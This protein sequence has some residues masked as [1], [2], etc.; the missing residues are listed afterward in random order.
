MTIELGL[1]AGGME[2]EWNTR[3]APLA[4]LSVHYQAQKRFQPLETLDIG[5]KTVRYSPVNK[6][7]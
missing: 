7:K 6:L 2:G 1:L 4:A 5:M 3:Y